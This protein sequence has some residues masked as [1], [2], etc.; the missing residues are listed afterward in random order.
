[1]ASANAGTTQTIHPDGSTE[2]ITQGPDPR[3]D[4]AAPVIT[5]DVIT[6]P[7]G[8]THTLSETRTAAVPDGVEATQPTSLTNKI[9][10]N[11]HTTTST[12]TASNHTWLTTSPAG[13]TATTVINDVGQSLSIQAG[14]KPPPISAIH[15]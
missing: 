2:S 10:V 7:S 15:F 12:Y 6:T 3:F 1:M 4:M 14:C 9:T 8:L 11:G 13:R 5:S